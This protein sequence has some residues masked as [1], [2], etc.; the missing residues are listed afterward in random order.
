MG[1]KSTEKK[2][3]T[4]FNTLIPE[5]DDHEILEIL[6]KRN[7]YQPDAANLALQEAIRRGLIHSEADLVAE[8]FRVKEM[9]YVLFPP[10]EKEHQKDRIRKSIARGLVIS[11]ILPTVWGFVRFNEG[12]KLEGGILILLG[13]LWIF[14][15]SRLFRRAEFKTIWIMLI[16]LIASI[17][18]VVKELISLK[19]IV[20]MD[21]LIPVV[22]YGFIVYGLLFLL[23][24]DK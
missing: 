19:S 21:I 9:R 11:G 22:V 8:E 15:S 10:I 23:K 12:V 5:Y 6:K 14:L 3:N 24:M 16:L 18:Y 20:F 7:Y 2:L 4:D 1:E 17:I 13:F